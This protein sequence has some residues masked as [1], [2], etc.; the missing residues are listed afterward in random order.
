VERLAHPHVHDVR[1]ALAAMGELALP[2][3][4]LVDDLA[5][6]EI[7]DE[8][9]LAGRA[10]RARHRAARL[11]RDAHGVAR[12][13]MRH[14]HALDVV[15]VGEPQQRLARLAVGARLLAH[16]LDGAPAERGRE[17]LPQRLGEIGELHR[18]PFGPVRRVTAD[19][20]RAIGRL[21]PLA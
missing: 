14:E 8:P 18:R 12:A 3:T 11:G 13:V 2:V 19:L 21:A 16:E 17:R 1:D 7:A 15:P 4:D 10:E 5:D 9:H 6:R 20:P